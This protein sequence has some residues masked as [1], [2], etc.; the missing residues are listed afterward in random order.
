M[1]ESTGAAHERDEAYRAIGRYVV[2]F[3]VM[4]ACMKI[5]MTTRLASQDRQNQILAAI[6]FGEATAKQVSDAFFAMCL[7]VGECDDEGTKIVGKLQAKINQEI[8]RRNDFA[9]GD[10]WMGFGGLNASMVLARYKPSRR[11]PGSLAFVLAGDARGGG[12][13]GRPANRLGR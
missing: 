11:L 12:Q 13:G 3:S 9:H 2:D 6:V 5:D 4:V 8:T 10:W 1:A 7:A